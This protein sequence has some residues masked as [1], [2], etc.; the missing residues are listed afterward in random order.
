MSIVSQCQ[1]VVHQD[2]H[3]GRQ[4]W[5]MQRSPAVSIQNGT[6]YHECLAG[7]KAAASCL[8]LKTPWLASPHGNVQSQSIY[9]PYMPPSFWCS[10]W[11]CCTWHV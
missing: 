9:A 4:T 7:N 8:I 5:T 3:K 2:L 10:V 6:G 1:V 11:K